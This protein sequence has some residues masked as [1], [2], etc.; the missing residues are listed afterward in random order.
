MSLPAHLRTTLSDIIDAVK[1]D[2]IK[3][4]V[5]IFQRT[6]SQ[7]YRDP[8]GDRSKN[9][10]VK[11]VGD[12]E[13]GYSLKWNYNEQ[14]GPDAKVLQSVSDLLNLGSLE[15][16]KHGLLA[17]NRIIHS[18]GKRVWIWKTH[19]QVINVVHTLFPS[20]VAK[21]IVHDWYS[22]DLSKKFEAAVQ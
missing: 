10:N 3:A 19:K 6:W 4:C 13:T 1:A 17:C 14:F 11:I 16:T 21:A 9:I 8:D 5:D 12:L 7:I 20:M 22:R 15:K 18:S 2:K